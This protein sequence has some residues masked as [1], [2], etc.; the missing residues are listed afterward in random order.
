GVGDL[1]KIARRLPHCHIA[2]GECVRR[3]PN[4]SQPFRLPQCEIAD[5]SELG[6][7]RGEIVRSRHEW[8]CVRAMFTHDDGAVTDALH[9]PW[10]LRARHPATVEVEE[11]RR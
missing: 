6:R 7:A 4:L 8:G 2:T 10:P 11:Q 9:E 5:A 1:E 3:L